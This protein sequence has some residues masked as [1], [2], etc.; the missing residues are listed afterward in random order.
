M[1][2]SY[3]V[4]LEDTGDNTGDVILPIPDEILTELNWNEGDTLSF[5]MENESI[6]ISKVNN[7]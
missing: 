6:I 7:V 3:I 2:K 4:S 5:K 1:S